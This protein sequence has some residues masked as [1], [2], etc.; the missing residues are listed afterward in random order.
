MWKNY[1]LPSKWQRWNYV[2]DQLKPL[3][4]IHFS[5]IRQ[6]LL[7][8][9][10]REYYTQ[11]ERNK[12]LLLEFLLF[13]V[14]VPLLKYWAHENND[15]PVVSKLTVWVCS[16]SSLFTRFPWT[17]MHLIMDMWTYFKDLFHLNTVCWWFNGTVLVC[18]SDFGT[19]IIHSS[20]DCS[21]Q[22]TFQKNI[23][24]SKKLL[25]P[26]KIDIHLGYL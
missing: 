26:F 7:W 3:E 23:S 24:I 17:E 18:D 8:V 20:E 21:V 10:E 15:E 1:L 5:L 11:D 9:E 14:E 4:N 19:N 2:H 13:L 6:L 12:S 25:W 16:I 22:Y